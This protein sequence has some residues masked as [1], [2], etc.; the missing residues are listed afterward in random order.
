MDTVEI[1]TKSHDS[2]SVSNLKKIQTRNFL[3]EKISITDFADFS[4]ND[5]NGDVKFIGDT[6]F[7]IGRKDIMSV[8]F[9]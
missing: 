6:I 5:A 4:L 7:N 3:G 2:I 8:L 9:K 1:T